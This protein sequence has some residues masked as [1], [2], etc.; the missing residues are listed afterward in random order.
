MVSVS[1]LLSQSERVVGGPAGGDKWCASKREKS[2]C[3]VLT[4][5]LRKRNG[6]CST[7]ILWWIDSTAREHFRWHCQIEIAELN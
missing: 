1:P 7:I 2:K 6:C 5:V 3:A 4:S